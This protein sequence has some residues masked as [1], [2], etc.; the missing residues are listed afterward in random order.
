MMNSSIFKA[1]QFF[2]QQTVAS[3]GYVGALAAFK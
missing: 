2:W 1:W 3:S